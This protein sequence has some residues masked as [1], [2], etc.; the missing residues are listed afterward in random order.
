ME[1]IEVNR[2]AAI[3]VREGLDFILGHFQELI[4]PR[5][6]STQTTEGR[7]VLAYNKE[8]V[9]AWFEA[10]N[11][12][13]CRI[14]GYHDYTEWNGINRQA[15]NFIFIDP[16]L[17]R[18]NC[19]E[20]VDRVVEKTLKNMKDKLKGAYPTVIW[21]GNGYHIYLPLEAFMLESVSVFASFENPSM[22]FLRF[23]EPYLTNN[24]ADPSHSNWHQQ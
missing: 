23:A 11:F 7:Q 15:P 12:L 10:A 21:T 16:D 6:I 18:F 3:T 20:T 2:H 5:T 13:D 17:S 14:N 1:K 22:K 8:E 19:M 4:W 24:K 9:L